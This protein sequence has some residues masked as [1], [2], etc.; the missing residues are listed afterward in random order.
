MIKSYN[1]NDPVKAGSLTLRSLGINSFMPSEE[2]VLEHNVLEEVLEDK[3][4]R[5]QWF[6]CG[7]NIRRD[8]I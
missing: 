7:R 3:W 6:G 4:S 8:R 5:S 2:K 1:S